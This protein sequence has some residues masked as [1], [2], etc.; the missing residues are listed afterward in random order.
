MTQTAPSLWAS[1][2]PDQCPHTPYRD[3]L[4]QAAL[5]ENAEELRP[6]RPLG[7]NGKHDALQDHGLGALKHSGTQTVTGS[8]TCPAPEALPREPL[9]YSHS[10]SDWALLLLLLLL[11]L[12]LHLLLPS[13]PL[14]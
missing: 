9:I 12:I 14:L 1:P 4:L 10:D 6:Q 11:L 5:G 8:A 13:S 3:E 2:S 7:E